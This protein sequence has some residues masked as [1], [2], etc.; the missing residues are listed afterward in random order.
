MD[1]N[2]YDMI[3]K[4]K[5]FHL[6]RNIRNQ[7]I[8]EDELKEIENKLSDFFYIQLVFYFCELFGVHFSFLVFFNK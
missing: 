4:R 1:N 2:L 5:S 3:F 6:F 8:S 7:K